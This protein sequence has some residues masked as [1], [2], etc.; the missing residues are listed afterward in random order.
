MKPPQRSEEWLQHVMRRE[1]QPCRL[2]VPEAS[3]SR[4]W[5]VCCEST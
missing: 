2:T 1:M 3:G 4:I 5:W